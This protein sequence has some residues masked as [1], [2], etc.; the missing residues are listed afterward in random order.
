MP[1]TS[2][3]TSEEELVQT[4]FRF[5]LSLSGD[6]HE[7][8]DLVQQ[9]CL[10]VLSKKGQLESRSYLLATIRNLLP[11]RKNEIAWPN[12]AEITIQQELIP[13]R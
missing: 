1:P 10:R 13:M 6:R 9:A 11:K 3:R 2:D 12:A 7:A 5:A 4:G 8:E